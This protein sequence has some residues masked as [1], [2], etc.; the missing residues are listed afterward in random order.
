MKISHATHIKNI[1]ET[2]GYGYATTNMV[3]SLTRLGY[4]I[5]QNDAS[6]DVQIAFDQP[7]QWRFIDGIYRI[8]YHP[9]ESTKLKPGWVKIMNECD[10]I[11]T[12][13]PLIADWYRADGITV[14]VH[15]YEHGVDAKRWY[16]KK[17]KVE[18]K[19]R[20]LHVGL[21]AA[22]KGGSETMRAFRTAFPN[23]DD[24]ELTMKTIQDGWNIDQIGR[25]KIL[26]KKMSLT[27]LVDLFHAHHVFVYPSYGEGFG[28][29]PLQA[30]AT[31][32]PVITV[33]AW[34]PYKDFLDPNLMVDSLLVK[35]QWSRGH[36]PGKMFKPKFDDIV[37]RM[38]YAYE[39][40]DEV[41]CTAHQRTFEIVVHYDW[42]R[43]TKEAFGALENRLEISEKV[44]PANSFGGMMVEHQKI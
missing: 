10:E 3:A 30:M 11:W 8:G 1:N 7:H 18:N 4:H 31:G 6:A 25:A 12:P 27:A 14:P 41:E 23:N 5:E 39:N 43:L 28:L 24:V 26:N 13:S 15:V 17:R 42:D 29:N 37:D 33:P 19:M 22:R 2:N 9:W 34:A 38:R 16:P 44:L 36:H 32:M 20:F 35:T 40:Y 21:E